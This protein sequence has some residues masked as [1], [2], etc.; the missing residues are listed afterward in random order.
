MASLLPD[1]VDVDNK[2]SNDPDQQEQC[3]STSCIL[4]LIP[5]LSALSVPG[6][7]RLTLS[8]SLPLLVQGYTHQKEMTSPTEPTRTAAAGLYLPG[9]LS[10]I[11]NE[12]NPQGAAAMDPPPIPGPG[13][14]GTI[15]CPAQDRREGK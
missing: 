8:P 6:G 4:R 5:S 15:P 12:M 10:H 9:N 11:S 7:G 2:T 13:S 1:F 3:I 14:A